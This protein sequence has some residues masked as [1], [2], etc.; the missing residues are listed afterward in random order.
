M[1]GFAVTPACA[2]ACLRAA[3]KQARRQVA[4]HLRIGLPCLCR[5]AGSRPHLATTPLP[6]SYPLACAQRASRSAPLTPGTG[7]FTPQVLSHVRHGHFNAFETRAARVEESRSKTGSATFFFFRA[8]VIAYRKRQK[9]TERT[10]YR[11]P[12]EPVNAL[13]TSLFMCRLKP[14]LFYVPAFIKYCPS[15]E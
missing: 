10:T 12:E 11:Y 6:F 7:A 3:R 13:N 5:Q 15:I 9:D 8:L 2:F 1:E 4:P 14:V